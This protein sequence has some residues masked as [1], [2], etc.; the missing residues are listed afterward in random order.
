MRTVLRV[1]LV[2]LA[3]LLPVAVVAQDQS[4]VTGSLNGT[5]SDATGAVIPDATVTVTGPQ[6]SIT[7]HTDNNGRFTAANLLPGFYDVKVAKTGFAGIE[8]K[9][10]EVTVSVASTLTLKMGVGSE[11]TT[12]EVTAAAV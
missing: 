3:I 12:V 4:A 6:G 9:H 1:L 8:A 10:N 11:S 5:V 2:G 7:T